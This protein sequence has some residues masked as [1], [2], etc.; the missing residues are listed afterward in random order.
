MKLKFLPAAA[1]NNYHLQVGIA[2][3]RILVFCA[4]PASVG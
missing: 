4:E 2:T 3:L 1:L